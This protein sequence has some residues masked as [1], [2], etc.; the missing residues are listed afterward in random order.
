MKKNNLFSIETGVRL[1]EC[2]EKYKKLTH[3]KKI[4]YCLL[5]E[6]IID[7]LEN[8]YSHMVRDFFY[9]NVST[10]RRPNCVVNLLNDIAYTLNL[11]RINLNMAGS[12]KGFVYGYLEYSYH[13]KTINCAD[14]NSATLIPNNVNEIVMDTTQAKFVLIVE[15]FTIFNQLIS[16]NIGKKFP[17]IMVIKLF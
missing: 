12:N 5:I 7:G 14:V 17:L 2:G 15:K 16:N 3:L 4:K 13:N 1:D 11:T 10:F 6:K 8:N 9:Q